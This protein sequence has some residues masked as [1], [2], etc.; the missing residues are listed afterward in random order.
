MSMVDEYINKANNAMRND[1]PQAIDAV[2]REIVAAFRSE[3]PNLPHYRGVRAID[4]GP[5][6]HTAADLKK[7][8]GKLR[9]FQEARDVELYSEYGL[10]AIT[11]SI[12]QLQNSI[13]ENYTEEQFAK[14]FSKIDNIYANRYKDYA[15]GLCG[16]YFNEDAADESQAQLRIEKLQV[17][18]DEEL[19][20]LKL[21][22][23]QSA[24]V[25]VTQNQ[26]QEAQVTA[27]SIIVANFGTACER[28]DEIPDDE[29]SDD[30]KLKLK[31]LLA[32]LEQAKLKDTTTKKGKLQKVLA[33]LADK[34]ADAAIAAAPYVG[35]AVQQL[36]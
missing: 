33:F 31:G 12:R 30:D 4:G 25:N 35:A 1:D 22:Q 34:G 23:F 14:L 26:S 15:V 11:D 28:I 24:P 2:A 21:A 8:I 20:K 3:I 17:F 5:N 16:Y 13:A 29:L 36:F 9:V 27:T 19:R 32:E 7:L 6:C 10:V 18:R